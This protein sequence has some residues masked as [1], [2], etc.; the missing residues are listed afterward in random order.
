M[1]CS[2]VRSVFL[3]S[4]VNV[5]VQVSNASQTIPMNFVRIISPTHLSKTDSKEE[6]LQYICDS[7]TN[8]KYNP[9]I[10]LKNF[11]L[12]NFK[13]ILITLGFHVDNGVQGLE[14]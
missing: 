9:H 13:L 2:T 11:S 12:E 1:S 14:R 4:N 6:N 10:H 7:T 5:M 8:K 3:L